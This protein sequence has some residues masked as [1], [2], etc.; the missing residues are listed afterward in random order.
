MGSAK[1]INAVASNNGRLAPTN[2][3]CKRYP[4]AY[5]HAWINIAYP[6]TFKNVSKKGMLD[7]RQTLPSGVLTSAFQ[8][9]ITTEKQ[10][11]PPKEIIR[12]LRKVI[13]GQ[14][15]II[16]HHFVL[17]FGTAT[18]GVIQRGTERS[19]GRNFSATS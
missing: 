5:K 15:N 13:T 3:N 7:E 18:R 4:E 16:S 19:M 10:E 11:N 8:P 6:P 2:K 14:P 9:E 17:A 1:D 12:T